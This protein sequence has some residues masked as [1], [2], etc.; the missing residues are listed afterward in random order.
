MTDIGRP[1]FLTDEEASKWREFH[2][3]IKQIEFPIGV[4]S[5]FWIVEHMLQENSYY[6]GNGFKYCFWFNCEED[7]NLF[8]VKY[9]KIFC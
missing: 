9:N 6:G 5:A 8:L 1:T 7:K 2:E 3:W 4:S